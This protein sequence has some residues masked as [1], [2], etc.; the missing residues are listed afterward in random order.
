MVWERLGWNG[1]GWSVGKVI[2]LLTDI[3]KTGR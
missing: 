1:M 2:K 3:I